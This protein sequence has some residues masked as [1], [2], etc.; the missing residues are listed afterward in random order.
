MG[1]KTKLMVYK[2]IEEIYQKIDLLTHNLAD[3][4]NSDEYESVVKKR[5][6]LINK[7]QMYLDEIPNL[8][9]GGTIQELN[10][11]KERIKNWIEKIYLFDTFILS[12]MSD[13]K[14]S[15]QQHINSTVPKVR[16]SNAY[17]LN[18]RK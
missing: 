9:D 18:S 1:K 12:K 11:I 16:V 13:E 8:E 2:E 15:I 7:T 17:K 6:S 5:E 14:D 4:T 3:I 10:L